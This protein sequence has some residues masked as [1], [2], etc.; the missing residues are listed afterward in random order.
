MLTMPR[1][2]S[3]LMLAILAWVVSGLVK[4]ALPEDVN[5]GRVV[6]VAVVVGFLCGW[7][8]LG[9]R[10][11]GTMGFG[12]AAGIGL[13]AALL[14]AGWTLLLV[15]L[16]EMLRLAINGRFDGP[17]E[18]LMSIIPIGRDYGQ[19]L[20]HQDIVLTL[21]IGGV[22]CGILAEIAGRRWN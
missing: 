6:M 3:A 19:H 14:L 2:L 5:P 11:D 22:V 8:M 16:N 20:M 13:T 15:C 4:Q 17:M 18:A 7:Y 9:R 1:F 12:A 10:A 21:L